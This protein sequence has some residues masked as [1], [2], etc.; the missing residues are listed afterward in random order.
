MSK[1]RTHTSGCRANEKELK[2]WVN[3]QGKLTQSILD[4]I[5]N[6]DKLAAEIEEGY[7][8]MQDENWDLEVANNMFYYYRDIP[9]V[10][11]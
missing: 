8:K 6:G 10:G 11:S 1:F 2:T 5:P 9:E 3:T 7:I 4:S